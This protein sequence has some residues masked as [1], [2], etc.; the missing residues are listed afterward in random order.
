MM[1]PPL[2]KLKP[3]VGQRFR[4]WMIQPRLAVLF[5]FYFDYTNCSTFPLA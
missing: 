3:E 5:F 2:R 4:S 1:G